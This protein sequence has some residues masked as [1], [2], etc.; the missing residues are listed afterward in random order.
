MQSKASFDRIRKHFRQFLMVK[1][2][3]GK[4]YRFR[5]YGPRVLRT[6]LPSCTHEE[7]QQFFGPVER[8]HAPSL[9]G[10]AVLSY[11]LSTTGLFVREA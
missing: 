9:D 7:P 10:R 2:E 11:C 3:A 4:K 8:F 1:D 5:F 6:F